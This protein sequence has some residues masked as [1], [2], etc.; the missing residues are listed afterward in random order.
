MIVDKAKVTNCCVYLGFVIGIEDDSF[1][2]WM[3]AL[4]TSL[5]KFVMAFSI[6]VDLVCSQVTS[7]VS[8]TILLKCETLSTCRHQQRFTI[9]THLYLVLRGQLGQQ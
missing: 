1:G 3:N 4:A 2:L 8:I 7:D 9:S 6:G 5:H